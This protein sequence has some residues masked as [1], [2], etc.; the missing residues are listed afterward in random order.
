MSAA[1]RD[2]RPADWAPRIEDA[3]LLCGAGRFMDDVRTA[4]AAAAC[5]VR[6]PHAF[7][8]IEGVD[9]SEARASPGVLA[10]L[11]AE[12][13]TQAGAGSLSHPVPQTGL[14]VPPWPALAD[15]RVMHVGQ[16]VV[17]V[18]AETEALA[19]DAAELVA[20]DYQPLAAVVGLAR[21][22]AP[23][24]P[25]LWPEAPG[26]L[27]LDWT[28]PLPQT[29]EDRREVAR[30]FAAA[31]H[32]AKV[33]VVNQPIAVASLETRGATASYD[34]ASD[35]YLLRAPSQGVKMLR[36]QLAASMSLRPDQLRLLTG[37]VGGAFGMKTAA[38]AEYVA[39]LVAAKKIGR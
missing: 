22:V 38:Y 27:A 39:L 31:A 15:G 21:A 20:I 32:V 28:G 35:R 24:A 19:Q 30:L 36:D 26:N 33:S 2:H 5:F 9:T 7:A 25:R 18:V 34:P 14:V 17:L 11:T 37:D 4:R 1:D 13:M 12:D 8:R 6:S 23:D 16:P 10:V 29:E 3:A